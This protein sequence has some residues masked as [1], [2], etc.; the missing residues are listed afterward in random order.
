VESVTVNAPPSATAHLDSYWESWNSTDALST[1]V[2]MKFDV[3]CIT[4]GTF[5]S[6]GNNTFSITG[7]DC[8]QATLTQ[9]MSNEIP[10]VHLPTSE[11]VNCQSI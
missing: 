11:E 6:L 7:L 9:F 10:T 3:V 4:F 1:I 5:T 2:E 8:D